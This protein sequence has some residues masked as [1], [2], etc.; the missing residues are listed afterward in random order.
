MRPA[1]IMEP[2]RPISVQIFVDVEDNRV[3]LLEQAAFGPPDQRLK[4]GFAMRQVIG[5]NPI[6][7]SIFSKFSAR[8]DYPKDLICYRCYHRVEVVRVA[9]S[10]WD[11][12]ASSSAN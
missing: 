8:H 10:T 7:R 11:C 4:R 1:S 3:T 12:I 2:S 5:S 9:D 6:A